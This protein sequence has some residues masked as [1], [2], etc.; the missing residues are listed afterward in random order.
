MP[1]SSLSDVLKRISLSVMASGV[2]W[3]AT[4]ASGTC[5]VTKATRSLSLVRII[6]ER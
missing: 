1:K 5:P 3:E 4:L 2:R 6:S